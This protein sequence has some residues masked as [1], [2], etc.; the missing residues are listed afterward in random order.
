MMHSFLYLI[1]LPLALLSATGVAAPAAVESSTNVVSRAAS[2]Y[3]NAAY[4]VNW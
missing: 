3:R 2:G 4:F 1:L